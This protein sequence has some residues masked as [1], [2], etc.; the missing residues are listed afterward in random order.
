ML[1]D[2]IFLK[3]LTFSLWDF[4]GKIAHFYC[5]SNIMEF[6]EYYFSGIYMLLCILCHGVLLFKVV[7]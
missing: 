7:S 2:K 5:F 3:C 6:F 1:L 4:M